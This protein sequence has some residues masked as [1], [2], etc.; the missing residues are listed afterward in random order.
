MKQISYDLRSCISILFLLVLL[1]CSK[2]LH[3]QSCTYSWSVQNSGTTSQLNT[4]SA[5]S[6]MIS[7][8]A[9][10]NHVVRRT[11]DGGATWG[12]GNPASPSVIIGNI[13]NIYAWSDIDAVCTTTLGSETIIYKT[14]NGGTT[15]TQVYTQAG[16]FINAIQMISATEGYAFGD[17]VGGKWTVLKTANAGN[18][19]AR[20]ATEPNV[21][22]EYS[23]LNAFYI[24]ENRVLLM[25]INNCINQNNSVCFNKIPRCLR[26]GVSFMIKQKLYSRVM[27]T[28]K[29]NSRG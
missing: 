24:L 10:S 22:G 2:Y 27:M 16:G 1:S 7:W 11:T 18:N 8:A 19:W 12:S 4:V 3:S 9:G 17:P 23:S 14:T 20:I 6:D 26:R 28:R 13:L 5:V 21:I 25:S 15:W 29:Q